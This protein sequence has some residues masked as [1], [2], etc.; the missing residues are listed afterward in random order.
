MNRIQSDVVY[1]TRLF[2]IDFSAV[3][4]I[5]YHLYLKVQF[6]TVVQFY[7]LNKNNKNLMK[8]LFNF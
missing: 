1:S 7:Y 3:F 4:F 5:I 6:I 2:K 8:M